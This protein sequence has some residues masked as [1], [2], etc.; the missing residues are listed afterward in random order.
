[1]TSLK[2][3]LPRAGM[4]YTEDR[5]IL[6]R[7]S[8]DDKILKALCKASFVRIAKGASDKQS[9]K[10]VNQALTEIF[11]VATEPHILNLVQ[12]ESRGIYAFWTSLQDNTPW[13]YYIGETMFFCFVWAMVKARRS[14]HANPRPP[15]NISMHSK[16]AIQIDAFLEKLDI[17]Y[18]SVDDEIYKMAGRLDEDED[19]DEEEEDENEDENEDEDEDQDMDQ[20][21]DEDG[22]EDEDQV[23]DELREG[24]DAMQ[25]DDDL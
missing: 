8:R 6:G 17:Y 16:T 4:V 12:Y 23:E 11:T 1:M 14:W 18:S 13:A 10:N 20:V 2:D 5:D 22:D 7:Q 24:V 3:F 9:K 15:F 21:E 25:I 19:D